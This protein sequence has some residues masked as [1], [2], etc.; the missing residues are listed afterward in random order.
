MPGLFRTR[1]YVYKE[2]GEKIKIGKKFELIVPSDYE[3]GVLSEFRAANEQD[4]LYFHREITDENFVHMYELIPGQR[5]E[6][7]VAHTEDQDTDEC[8]AFVGSQNAALQTPKL[9]PLI[10][11]QARNEIPINKWCILFAA[12]I[13][14]RVCGI[15]RRSDGE[16]D[17]NMVRFENGWEGCCFFCIQEVH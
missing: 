8:L 15:K 13:D 3:R 4:I 10:L 17:I 16:W 12:K 7:R 9:F 11:E 6:V 14:G 2:G 1:Q 5:L